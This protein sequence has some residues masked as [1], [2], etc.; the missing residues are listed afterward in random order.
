VISGLRWG[1]QREDS[2]LLP[3]TPNKKKSV[4]KKTRAGRSGGFLAESSRQSRRRNAGPWQITLFR[5][6]RTARRFQLDPRQFESVRVGDELEKR[7]NATFK[8]FETRGNDLQKQV[9]AIKQNVESHSGNKLERL[10][11]YRTAAT[12][13]SRL[14][15]EIKQLKWT[16]IHIRKR[17]RPISPALQQAKEH[18]SDKDP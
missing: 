13:S 14:L 7:W 10:D 18:D 12:E 4:S 11:A 2:G 16:S 5:N 1:T 15:K 6:W 3:E 8:D 9:D 17:L